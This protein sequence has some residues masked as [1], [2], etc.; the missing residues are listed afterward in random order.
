MPDARGASHFMLLL[1][2]WIPWPLL[3]FSPITVN[4]DPLLL[5]PESPNYMRMPRPRH[6]SGR[7]Q[8]RPVIESP[9]AAAGEWRCFTILGD[10][11]LGGT[12]ACLDVTHVALLPV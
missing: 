5:F 10:A 2:S 6:L 8:S 11:G 9:W 1:R 4:L 3:L 7:V 12:T